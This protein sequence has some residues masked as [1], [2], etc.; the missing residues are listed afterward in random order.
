MSLAGVRRMKPLRRQG[1]PAEL[2]ANVVLQDKFDHLPWSP[3]PPSLS[4]FHDRVIDPGKP[5]GQQSAH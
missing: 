4:R 3:M 2:P 1:E 5:A